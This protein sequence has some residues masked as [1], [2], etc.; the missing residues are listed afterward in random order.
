MTLFK[1][2]YG[3][4]CEQC[5]EAKKKFNKNKLTIFELKQKLNRCKNP[6]CN[7]YEK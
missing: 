6:E 2:G 5:S 1:I 3:W 4:E 7:N